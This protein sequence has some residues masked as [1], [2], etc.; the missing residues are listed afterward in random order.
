ML[1][2]AEYASATGI[3]LQLP[4]LI[5]PR[6]SQGAQENRNPDGPA[7]QPVQRSLC[8]TPVR[9]AALQP[10]S[11]TRAELLG[12]HVDPEAAPGKWDVED[13]E[14]DVAAAP[15]HGTPSRL[16]RGRALRSLRFPQPET[17]Q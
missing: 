11:D 12:V 5:L 13:A 6:C 17:A 1:K 9:A 8:D 15:G 3:N 2:H 14:G 16:G 7:A 10:L 4:L